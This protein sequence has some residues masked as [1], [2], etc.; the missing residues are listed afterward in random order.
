[1]ASSLNPGD[2]TVKLE[3]KIQNPKFKIGALLSV[4]VALATL[5]SVVVPPFE[6]SDELWHYPMVKHIADNWALPVQDPE[7]VGPW[8]QEGSQPPLYYFIAAVAT[9]WIDTSDVETVR[10]LNP[11]ADNGIATPDGNVNLISHNPDAESFPWR[12]ATLAVH[13][14]RFLSV[15]MG[16]ATVYLTYH[17]ALELLPNHPDVALVAAAINAFT[18]MFVFISG[19]VN[20]DNLVAPLCSLAL[21][22]MVRIIKRTKDERQKTNPESQVT[23]H[24]SRFTILGLTVGLALLT[25]ES[26][27]GLVLLTALT[28]T[29]VAWRERSLRAF[30]VGGLASGLPTVLIAGW[31][32]WRNWRL[33]GDL[34]GQNVFIE[35]LGQ[36]DVPADLAQLWRERISFM[37]GYWGN[38]GGLNVPMPDWVY[39]AFDALLLLAALGLLL[40]LLRHAQCTNLPIYQ[41]LPWLLTLLWP[42][43]VVV[44]WITWAATT[45]SSQGRLVFSAISVWS[46]LLA[47]GARASLAPTK[48]LRSSVSPALHPQRHLPSKQGGAGGASVISVPLF[49]FL[50]SLVAPFAWIRPA[51]A[52]PPALTDAQVAAIPNRVDAVFFH[53]AGGQLKLLGYAAPVAAAYPGQ[54]VPVTLYWE[55]VEPF[56]RDY[57]VFLHLVD[58]YD[59]IAAQRD[60]FPG[61]GTLSTQWLKPGYRWSERRVLTLPDTAYSPNQTVFEVGLYDYATDER[62]AVVDATGQ[63]AGDHVRFGRV[64]VLVKDPAD[65]PNPIS[66]DFGG[67]MELIGYDLDRRALRAGETA[68]LSLYWRARRSIKTNYSIS[69]QFVDALQVKA[70]QKDAWPLDGAAPTSI[71]KPGEVI[72]ERREL[73]VFEGALPGVYDV[74][75][76]AYPADDPQE[77]LVV[78][79]PGGRLQTNHVVLTTVR[80]LP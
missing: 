22:L 24:V 53:P 37:R 8:R 75:V 62:L 27:G 44:L 56:Q 39:T 4:F 29:F 20:N 46:L 58:E 40:T 80:V 33:Y 16:A 55:A 25:K 28:V 43:L 63:I 41:H 64:N 60:A 38:F 70:A 15:L 17:L 5:Y 35:I 47:L 65:W 32:Y 31:W 45:W 50:V 52:R 9:F 1:V 68:T 42:A 48:N 61:M 76:T 12:G 66:V 73:T 79:P 69:T 6:A 67:Q 21:F 77:L 23:F 78:T 13:L 30:L 74:Y 57:S 2:V 19:A 51:Y 36:R 49:F 34:T 59:L 71:W 72:E 26:A 3:S 10:R 54:Q 11:H 14:I 18:P 7:N